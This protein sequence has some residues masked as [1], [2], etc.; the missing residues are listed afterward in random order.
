VFSSRRIER[1][2]EEDIAFRVLAAGNHPNFRT[3]SDFRKI[4]L[5]TLEG[6]FEQVLQ[7]A[8]EAG[9]LKLGRVALDG[10]KVKANASKHKAMSYDRIRDKEK[11]LRGEVKHL[12]A[13]AE[14]ADAEEDARYGKNSKGEELPPELE[15]RQSRI[16]K[17]REA[18]KALEQR[19]REK[20]QAEGGDPKQAQPK[21]KDQY[22][23]TD[24]ESR[25]MK[26]ADRFRAGLQRAGGRRTGAAADRRLC[27]DCGHQRQRATAA[28]GYGGGAAEWT[29]A[30]PGTGR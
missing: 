26:G 6:L 16:Q 17:I 23:F 14:A 8:L 2:L 15:R 18:K 19:A 20:A 5:K 22:N 28:D 11:A 29:K 13:Q 4:H 10:T 9:A 12:L 25:I 7:I 1:K 24:P 21:D 3:I 30:G 27:G